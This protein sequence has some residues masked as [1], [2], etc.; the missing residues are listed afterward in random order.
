[1]PPVQKVSHIWSIRF[2]TSPVI[3][4]LSWSY[5][6][7]AFK[8]SNFRRLLPRKTCVLCVLERKNALKPEFC[9]AI[10]LII[11]LVVPAY[12]TFPVRRTLFPAAPSD[13]ARWRG[14]GAELH[15]KLKKE[16]V[17]EQGRCAMLVSLLPYWGSFLLPS[18]RE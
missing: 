8:V 12:K 2:F 6:A 18:N 9:F 10:L 5:L 4:V 15:L 14:G 13:A 16:E 17:E 7:K 1:M 3:I 11:T